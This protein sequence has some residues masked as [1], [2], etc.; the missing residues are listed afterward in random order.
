MAARFFIPLGRQHRGAIAVAG[1]LDQLDQFGQ[2]GPA[3][4][5]VQRRGRFVQKQ[6]VGLVHDGQQD[7]ELLA[8][9]AR[10]AG[11]ALIERDGTVHIG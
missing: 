7:A 8:L 10:Q 11:D 6:N 5:L 1:Q 4:N 2:K 3:R 9:A